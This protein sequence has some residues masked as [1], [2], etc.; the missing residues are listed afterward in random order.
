MTV[1]FAAHVVVAAAAWLAGTAHALAEPASATAPPTDAQAEQAAQAEQEAYYAGLDQQI[2][3][4]NGRRRWAPPMELSRAA[5]AAWPGARV[6]DAACGATVCRVHLTDSGPGNM[7]EK[8]DTFV[9][10]L[11]DLQDSAGQPNRTGGIALRYYAERP[12]D[13]TVYLLAP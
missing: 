3:A 7:D 13:V 2:T 12:Q 8:V 10:R 5:R 11:S 6:S 9:R 4:R 1:P